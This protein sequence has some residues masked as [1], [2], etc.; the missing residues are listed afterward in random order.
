M[1]PLRGLLVLEKLESVFSPVVPVLD[2]FSSIVTL[3]YTSLHTPV[4][5]QAHVTTSR[6]WLV[7]GGAWKVVCVYVRFVCER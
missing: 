5:S 3:V 7:C 2:W 6:P 1:V 4:Y